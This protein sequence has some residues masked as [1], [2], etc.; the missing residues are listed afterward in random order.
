M[1]GMSNRCELPIKVVIF[2]KPKMLTGLHQ[3]VRGMDGVFRCHFTQSVIP[4]A[5]RQA[6]THSVELAEHGKPDCLH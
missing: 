4:S 3:K 6:L 1:D 5:D 2:Y